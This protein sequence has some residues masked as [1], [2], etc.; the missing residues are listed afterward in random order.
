[1]NRNNDDEL[2]D[3]LHREAAAYANNLAETESDPDKR[4]FHRQVANDIRGQIKTQHYVGTSE[5]G[6][7][8]GVP[9]RTV[10]KWL[11]RYPDCPQPDV[12]IG[13]YQSRE[14]AGWLPERKS[15]WLDWHAARPGHGWRKHTSNE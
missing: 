4:W 1:M 7:W 3:Q 8:F 2:R 5:V 15:E 9:A 11:Q 14:I 12:V 6:A 13:G 10:T